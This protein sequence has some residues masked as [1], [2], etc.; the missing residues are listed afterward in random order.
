M[1]FIQALRIVFHE[2]AP[3]EVLE[4]SCSWFVDFLGRL[5]GFKSYFR[6]RPVKSLSFIIFFRTVAS[7]NVLNFFKGCVSALGPVSRKSRELFGPE[8]PI[9]KLRPAYFVKLVF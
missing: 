9:L 5:S 2:N 8:K 6:I 3:E 4:M 7:E 1:W